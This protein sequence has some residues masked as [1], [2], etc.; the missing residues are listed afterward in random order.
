MFFSNLIMFFI[1]VTTAS[2]IG[3][4]GLKNIQTAD[5]A[6]SALKPF[7]GEFA[8]LL[9]ALGIIGTGLLAVPVLAGSVS[10]AISEAF[11]WKASLNAKPSKAKKFYIVIAIATILGLAVNFLPIKPFQLLYYTAV[12]NGVCS[13][14]LLILIM[15]ISNNK[16][17]MRGR[18]NSGFSNVLGWVI[19]F[20]MTGC[21][22]LLFASYFIH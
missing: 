4:H 2:T 22:I 20:V 11:N 17:I 6:A 15:K 13:P 16:E 10:Y 21:A 8:F 5:Q 3:L 7:A 1:I 14:I 12:L 19:T 18:T 9:F